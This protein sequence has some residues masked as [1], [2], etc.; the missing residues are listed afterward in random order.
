M[1]WIGRTT[2]EVKSIFAK[3]DVFVYKILK[4]NIFNG[5]LTSPYKE[6]PYEVGKTY[7]QGINSF[8]NGTGFAIEEGLHFYDGDCIVR[9][10][11]G[12]VDI[13]SR[14]TERNIDWFPNHSCEYRI[15]ICKCRIPEGTKYYINERGEIVTEKIEIVAEMLSYI[16]SCTRKFKDLKFFSFR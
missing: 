3:E 13:Y 16:P 1:C 11:G 14:N 15:T 12:Y 2:K 6:M 5:S 4:R 9:N 7:E 8:H 10:Y